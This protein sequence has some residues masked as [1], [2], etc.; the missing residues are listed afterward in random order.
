M[1]GLPLV[2]CLITDRRG[3]YKRPCSADLMAGLK[4]V[5]GARD[6]NWVFSPETPVPF[7][8]HHLPSFHYGPVL[9][10]KEAAFSH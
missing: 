3:T 1:N 4:Q 6:G 8:H 7:L 2:L 9:S 5:G 10:S